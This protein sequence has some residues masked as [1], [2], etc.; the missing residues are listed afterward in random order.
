MNSRK[1][2]LLITCFSFWL[3]TDYLVAAPEHKGEIF[4]VIGVSGI[5]DD[6][7]YLGSGF[8]YGVGVGLRASRRLGFEFEVDRTSFS[9]DF[10]SGLSFEGSEIVY[11]GNVQL[12]FPLTNTE[13]YIFGGAGVAHFEQTNRFPFDGSTEVSEFTDDLFTFQFGGGVIFYVSPRISLRPEFR[14]TWNDISF[15]NQIRGSVAVGYHW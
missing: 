13:P 2:A 15:I 14:W 12:Y 5:H 11:A 10:S 7:S 4:G 6:E 8:D 3:D 9:R 1:T